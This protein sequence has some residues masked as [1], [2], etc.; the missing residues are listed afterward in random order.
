MAPTP[1]N[2]MPQANAYNPPR[3]IE[4]YTLPDPVNDSIPD[5]IRNRYHRDDA[6]RVLFFTAPPLNR[7]HIGI[8]PESQGLGHSVR[9]LAGREEWLAEREKKRKE[10]DEKKAAEAHK[11]IE[12]EEQQKA[13]EQKTIVAHASEVLA[14]WFRKYDQETAQWRDQLLLDDWDQSMK[15]A[16][17]RGEEG[18]RTSESMKEN[19]ESGE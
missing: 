5:D 2:A 9:Y 16:K 12:M 19:M 4:V 15:A 6:G 14:G 10:R 1:G 7:P 17:M 18:A 13:Q 3:P 11:R 8:S